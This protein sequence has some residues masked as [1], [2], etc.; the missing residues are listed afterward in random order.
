LLAQE[1]IEELERSAENQDFEKVAENAEFGTSAKQK[2]ML[3]LRGVWKKSGQRTKTHSIA[4]STK[5]N[6]WVK[7]SDDEDLRD[8]VELCS[9][10]TS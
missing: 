8:L 4:L 6:D 9:I 1:L 7:S 10:V 3:A 2:A 5:M